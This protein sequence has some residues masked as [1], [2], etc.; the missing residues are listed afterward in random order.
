MVDS[1]PKFGYDKF[2]I[3]SILLLL[4]LMLFSK[5]VNSIEARY[6]IGNNEFSSLIDHDLMD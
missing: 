6:A 1:L 5:I 2:I 4:S 3:S